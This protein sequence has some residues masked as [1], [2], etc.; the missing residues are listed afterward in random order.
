MKKLFTLL[1]CIGLFS[2]LI[3]CD[4]DD[5]AKPNTFV[6]VHGAWQAPYVWQD[7]KT[8]LEAKGQNVLIV[9]LPAHGDDNTSPAT[10]SIDAYRDKVVAAINSV[11]GRVI[12]VGHSLGGMVVSAVAESIPSKLE[13]LIYIGAF[14]PANDQSLFD[15]ALQDA[16]SQLGASLVL[17]E[18]QLTW[19]VKSENII[20][21][22]C[23]D[24]ST[25]K[26]QLMLTNYRSEPTIPFTN[27]VT[28]TT[29]NFGKVDKYY[30]HTALD[31]AVG[32]D[33]Q[34]KMVTGAAIKHEY[35]RNTGHSPFLSNPEG[36]TSL[37]LEIGG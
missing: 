11:D 28:L 35:S 14:V 4:S 2:S 18:D 7:V 10:V 1:A 12:L 36:V 17:S 26:Q 16:Q 6:L 32:M 13:K 5:P 8:Q 21:I 24:A 33:L 30:I 15:L 3:S 22:F 19:D 20:S 34:N 23:Q 27:K 9:E 31:N 25:T 37:L 29:G